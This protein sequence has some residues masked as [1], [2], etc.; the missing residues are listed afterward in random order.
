MR[1]I[2]A[3]GSIRWKT[4]WTEFASNGSG[5][6]C[7]ADTL[8]EAAEFIGCDAED[9]KAQVDRINAFA[10]NHYDAEFLKVQNGFTL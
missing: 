8:E 3:H 6:V 4:I 2:R 10:D 7:K 1:T 5:L 9:L